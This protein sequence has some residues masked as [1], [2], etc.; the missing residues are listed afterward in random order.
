M[1]CHYCDQPCS[2]PSKFA[3]WQNDSWYD[4][5]WSCYH[6]HTFYHKGKINL[7]TEINGEEFCLQ[8][9]YEPS[10]FPA[11]L[12]A[13]KNSKTILNFEKHPDINP[14]NINEKVKTYILFS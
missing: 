13:T 11:S 6:C 2:Q 5:S 14:G 1:N 4:N 8:F 3:R 12:F 10:E 9:L 7:I